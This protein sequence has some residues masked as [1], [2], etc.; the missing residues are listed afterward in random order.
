MLVFRHILAQYITPCALCCALYHASLH[1]VFCHLLCP[2]SHRF[3]TLP[4]G[5]KRWEGS[6]LFQ[7]IFVV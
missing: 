6:I 7:L 4:G 1:G 2:H 3:T 5:R